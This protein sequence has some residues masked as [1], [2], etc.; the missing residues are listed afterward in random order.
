MHTAISTKMHEVIEDVKSSKV[1]SIEDIGEEAVKQFI[2]LL[3]RKRRLSNKEV[4][5]I[6]NAV[7]RARKFKS[8]KGRDDVAT[9]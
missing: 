4:A 2:G 8:G 3:Q 1:F 9:S 5:F 6:Q 7:A